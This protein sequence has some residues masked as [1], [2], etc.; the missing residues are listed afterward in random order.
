MNKKIF[1]ILFML[2]LA[3]ILFVSCS[4]KDKT[5]AGGNNTENPD[6]GGTEEPELPNF[7][8]SPEE[9]YEGTDAIVKL[10]EALSFNTI[11]YTVTIKD[12]NIE[13]YCKNGYGTDN[14]GRDKTKLEVEIVFVT[15]IAEDGGMFS[16]SETTD[17]QM[18]ANNITITNIPIP[19]DAVK[20]YVRNIN[21]STAFDKKY[22]L[23]Y[24]K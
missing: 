19:N 6:G 11:L 23:V 14:D 9:V 12:Q 4:N 13:F 17:K 2:L 3:G 10:N 21:L 5:G 24:T 7:T 18:T 22:Y 8:P 16:Y 1:T 20:V 15:S